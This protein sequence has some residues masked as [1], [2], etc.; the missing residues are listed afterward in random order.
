MKRGFT[1]FELILVVAMVGVLAVA[2]LPVFFDAKTQSKDASEDAVVGAVRDAL[3]IYRANDMA[4]NVTDG[5]YPPTL[6]ANQAGT[7]CDTCFSNIL[8]HGLKDP[9]WTKDTVTNYSF[10]NGKNYKSYVYDPSVGSFTE[11]TQ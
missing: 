10:Y 3:S 2:S 9:S 6:D 1:L 7:I 4:T 11:I 5:L 8:T